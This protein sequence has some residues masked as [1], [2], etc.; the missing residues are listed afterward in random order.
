MKTIQQAMWVMAAAGALT[1]AGCG[2]GGDSSSSDSG[3]NGGG[4]NNGGDSGGNNGGGDNGGGQQTVERVSLTG[5]AVKG[6]LANALITVTNLDGSTTYGTTRTNAQGRYSL[7]DLALGTGPVKVT[8]T[9]DSNTQ[10]TCDSAIGCDNNGIPVEFGSSYPFNDSNFELTAILPAVADDVTSV[11]LMVTPVT[12]M[13]AERVEQSGVTSADDIEGVNRATASL[14]GLQNVDITRDIPLDITNAQDSASASDESRRYGALVA[15]F[16]TIAA[17]SGESLTDVIEEVSDDYADDGGLVANSSSEDTIDLETIFAGA[18]DSAD[19]AE[20]EGADLGAADVEFRADQQQASHVPEDEEVIAVDTSTPPTDTLTQEQAITKAINLL[21]DMNEWNTALTGAS[22]ETATTAYMDQAEALTDFLPVIDDQSQVL[23]GLRELIVEETAQGE[24]QDG[25]LLRHIDLIDQLVDLSSYIQSNHGNLSATDNGDGTFTV[26]AQSL[27]NPDAYLAIEQFL[28]HGSSNGILPSSTEADVTATY[29]LNADDPERITSI[30]FSGK[31]LVSTLASGEL[32]YALE[33]NSQIVYTLSNMKVVGSDGEDFVA[34]GTLDMAFGSDADRATFLDDRDMSGRTPS[35]ISLSSVNLTLDANQKG[36]MGPDSDPDFEQATA[37]LDIS[38]SATQNAS[39]LVDIDLTVTVDLSTPDEGFARGT[40]TMK[41]QSQHNETG[42]VT[43]GFTNDLELSGMEMAFDGALQAKTLDNDSATFDGVVNLAGQNFEDGDPL[44][45]SVSFDG[46][47]G[48]SDSAGASLNFDGIASLKM[49]ALIASDNK[50]LP[51][52]D[53]L[54]MVP[55]Q[56]SLSG[57]LQQ[58]DGT[59]QAVVNLSAILTMDGYDELAALIAPVAFPEPGETA[60]QLRFEGFSTT[61]TD[62]A[63]NTA[64]VSLAHNFS[65]AETD[66]VSYISGLGLNNPQYSRDAA[67]PETV[68][69]QLSG[70]VDEMTNP[71]DTLRE[72]Q[73]SI[74]TESPTAITNSYT[75]T[76][77]VEQAIENDPSQWLSVAMNNYFQ[78][79]GI[80]FDVWADE[81]YFSIGGFVLGNPEDFGSTS[82]PLVLDLTVQAVNLALD[83]DD[84]IDAIETESIYRDV[85]LAADID[86]RALNLEDGNIRLTMERLGLDDAS[87]R[88]RFSYGPRNIDLI[89]NSINGL[90]NREATSLLIADA[91]TRMEIVATCATQKDPEEADIVACTDGVN[92]EGEV[93]VGDFK[94]GEL[95]DRDGFPVFTFDDPNNRQFKLVVTPN[96]LVSELQ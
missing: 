17:E 19:K 35:I 66:V 50:P 60:A 31:N 95:E 42:S 96:F 74:S 82:T 52:S 24:M 43:N 32:T 41:N 26:S 25:Q 57:T 84:I 16:S 58:T 88:L 65:N 48:I 61:S 77:V 75:Q 71:N 69:F 55:E 1:L 30:S 27:I 90:T 85:S 62:L 12:H 87:G 36:L 79:G 2:G 86:T 68:T 23:R 38:L 94:V 47:F 13:A 39:Q 83:A 18:A 7:A 14:L 73:L 45:Q 3:D 70:C 5:I 76:L 11:E 81:G 64:V 9:T 80:Q 37:D 15:S 8:M 91:D 4:N 40:L 21:E 10:L 46:E 49:A 20:D 34:S 67:Y 44:K 33:A 72:C 53:G 28:T 93:Y 51:D 56:V 29:S 89:I 92:F 78:G 6:V 59:D 54:L 63:S 22:T